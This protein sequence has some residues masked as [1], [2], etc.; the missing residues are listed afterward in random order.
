MSESD[1]LRGCQELLDYLRNQGKLFYCRM[2]SGMALMGSGKKKYAVK[3]SPEGTADL[4]IIRW[5]YPQGAPNK[6]ETIVT[7]IETKDEKGVQSE[8]Q[9]LFEQEVKEQGCQYYIV[10]SLDEMI[11][12]T[13]EW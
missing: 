4:L 5:W 10:R 1:I 13:G 2:N 8:A 12:I 3:L 11:A 7:W 6:G 9:K